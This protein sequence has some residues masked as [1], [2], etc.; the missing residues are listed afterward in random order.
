MVNKIIYQT[1]KNGSKTFFTS[2]LFFPKT[3]REDIFIFYSF[4]RTADDL[5]DCVPPQLETFIQFK[6][7]YSRGLRRKADVTVGFPII[8]RD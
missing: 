3:V 5:V 4:V 6:N 1:F 7:K 2:S 8:R